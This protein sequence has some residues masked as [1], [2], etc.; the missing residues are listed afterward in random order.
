MSVTTAVIG[1]FVVLAITIAMPLVALWIK[2][3]KQRKAP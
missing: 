3:H 2:E 1:T